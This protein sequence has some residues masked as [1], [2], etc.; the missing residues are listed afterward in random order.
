MREP[1]MD[2]RREVVSKV[3]A[4]VALGRAA[5]RVHDG[6][7]TEQRMYRAYHNDEFLFDAS[8]V[9]G[10]SACPSALLPLFDSIVS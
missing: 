6:I 8:S 2:K 7:K 5:D 9:G 3:Y 10:A 1:R 4:D